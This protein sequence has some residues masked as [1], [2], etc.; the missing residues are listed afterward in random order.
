MAPV[1]L[2]LASAAQKPVR[3]DTLKV[4]KHIP[5]FHAVDQFGKDRRF[6]DLV[7]PKGLVLFFYKSADW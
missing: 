4:G 5:D 7:G 2:V 3:P 6:G 1:I